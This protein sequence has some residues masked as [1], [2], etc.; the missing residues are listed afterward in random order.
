MANHSLFIRICDRAGF[1]VSHCGEGFFGK[2]ASYRKIRPE[3]S[4][5]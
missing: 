4:S 3:I 1:Q 5:G 2:H